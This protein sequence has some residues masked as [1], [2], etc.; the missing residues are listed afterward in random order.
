MGW[1]GEARWEGVSRHVHLHIGRLDSRARCPRCREVGRGD[2]GGYHE[3]DGGEE[4]EDILDAR[5]GVV[6][7]VRCCLCDRS[8][9]LLRVLVWEEVSYTTNEIVRIGLSSWHWYCLYEAL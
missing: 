6:H 1:A 8:K 7:L 5:E 2:D 9:C 3:C 4:A